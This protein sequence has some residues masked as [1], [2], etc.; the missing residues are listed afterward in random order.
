MKKIKTFLVASLAILAV[1]ATSCGSGDDKKAAPAAKAK[2]TKTDVH[3]LPN[4]RYVDLDSVLSK[5]NLAKDF[6]EEMLRMQ[7]NLA[8]AEK[9]HTTKIQNFANSM[10]NKMQN[11]SY[12]SEASYRQDEQTLNNMQNEAQKAMA[13]LQTN[14]QNAA[15]QGQQAVIDSITSFINEYNKTR[16]YD[17]IFQKASTLY[18]NP[19]LDITDEV[20]EGLNAR[21]NKVAK[22]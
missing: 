10:Q 19:E 18:I 17:A 7:N 1:I 15:L 9:Q 11:N 21:Y 4:Y 5:Y 2:T 14:M 22:K 12:L 13:N 8:S 16:G 20:V 3:I 6:N